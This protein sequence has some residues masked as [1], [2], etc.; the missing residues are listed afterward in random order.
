LSVDQSDYAD[1]ETV[2][3]ATQWLCRTR[4]KFRGCTRCACAQLF[5][6]DERISFKI[7]SLVESRAKWETNIGGAVQSR[8]VRDGELLCIPSMGGDLV[9]L[10]AADGSE[11]LSGEVGWTGL[12]DAARRRRRRLLHLGGSLHLCG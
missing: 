9:A 1:A 4:L 6:T 3:G 2:P 10:H 12:R 11:G 8:L 5:Q 7:R